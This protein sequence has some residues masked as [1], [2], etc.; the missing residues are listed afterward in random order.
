MQVLYTYK[1]VRLAN[2]INISGDSEVSLLPE[3][4]LHVEPRGLLSFLCSIT[5]SNHTVCGHFNFFLPSM[6]SS[7]EIHGEMV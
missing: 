4:D 1:L 2:P 3:S 5:Y 7:V 6:E